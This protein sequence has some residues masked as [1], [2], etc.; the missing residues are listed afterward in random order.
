MAPQKRRCSH[1]ISRIAEK[2]RKHARIRGGATPTTP[3]CMG[4][5]M[6]VTSGAVKVDLGRGERTGA[7]ILRAKCGTPKI[8]N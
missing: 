5:A 7:A 4:L 6:S 2:K 3:L 1:V 8:P